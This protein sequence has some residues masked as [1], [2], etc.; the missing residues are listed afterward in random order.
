[1]AD[2]RGR[3]DRVYRMLRRLDGVGSGAAKE[4]G[5]AREK[6]VDADETTLWKRGL[7]QLSP[8]P[9]MAPFLSEIQ[10]ATKPILD[11]SSL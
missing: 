10:S 3:R 1:M 7:L 11:S 2:V 5:V 8:G 4:E 9:P 6:L